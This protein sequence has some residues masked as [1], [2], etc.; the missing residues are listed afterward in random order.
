MM[1]EDE[2]D[3]RANWYA[4]P[5]TTALITSGTELVSLRIVRTTLA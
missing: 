5:K 4:E 1:Y 3:L 2:I